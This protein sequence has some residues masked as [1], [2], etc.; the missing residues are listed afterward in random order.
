MPVLS[1]FYGLIV[2][3]YRE[4]AGKHSKPHIHVKYAEFSVILTFD[5]EVLE[6]SL[7]P[8]KMKLILAWIELHR[9]E[10]EMNWELISE[11]HA[12]FKIDPLR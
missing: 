12:I 5:G 3:M 1:A 8:S 4:S 2:R 10:L 6:G 11:G 7:P 9:D